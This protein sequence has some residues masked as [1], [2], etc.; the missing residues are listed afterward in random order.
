MYSYAMHLGALFQSR[1]LSTETMGAK[2]QC[3]SLADSIEE[4]L[5]LSVDALR[6]VGVLCSL[7][8][9]CD[10]YQIF[11][12]VASGNTYVWLF[13][14]KTS[15][16]NEAQRKY[17][18]TRGKLNEVA[19]QVFSDWETVT[20]LENNGFEADRFHEALERRQSKYGLLILTL[21]D[22]SRYG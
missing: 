4:V 21:E 6:F 16:T 19:C 2:M 13:L 22:M 12:L 20:D 11:T 8:S 3:H 15:T 14:S 9:H 10:R 17:T 1:N 18:E 7:G 5:K